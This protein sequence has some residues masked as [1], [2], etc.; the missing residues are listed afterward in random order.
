MHKEKKKSQKDIEEIWAAVAQW[1]DNDAACLSSEIQQ[2]LESVTHLTEYEDEKA[3]RIMTAMAFVGAIVAAVHALALQYVFLH[4][5]TVLVVFNVLLAMFYILAVTGSWLVVH[6]IKPRFNIPTNRGARPFS[7]HFGP[8][9]ERVTGEVW[10]KEFIG[11]NEVALQAQN[12]KNQIAEVK[13]IAHKAARKVRT[14]TFATTCYLV[15]LFILILAMITLGGTLVKKSLSQKHVVVVFDADN[16]LWDTNALYANAQKA[17]VIGLEKMT[18]G[19]VEGDRVS[20]LRRFDEEIAKGH[21]NGFRYPIH[22]LVERIYDELAGK[23]GRKNSDPEIQGAFKQ[24]EDDYLARIASAPRLLPRAKEVLTTLSEKGYRL[25]LLSESDPSLLDERLEKNGIREFFYDVIPSRK[26]SDVFA[27]LKRAYS[28]DSN[29][30]FVSIGDRVDVDLK[31]AE[32]AG[33]RTIQVP[34]GFRPFAATLGC[35]KPDETVVSL[36][37]IPEKI[38][39]FR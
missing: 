25:V 26:S 37:E 11:K 33:Y 9:I 3:S 2:C 19:K 28:T 23:D 22:L 10:A 1:P 31:L 32:D 5:G 6:A 16:T 27:N 18:G 7:L 13:L 15:S 12:A 38:D 29:A 36:A 24:L 35:W 4:R 21:E 17:L 39:S 20:Y 14:L 8:E 30:V 34:G